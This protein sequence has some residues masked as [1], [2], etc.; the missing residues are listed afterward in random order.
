M[1]GGKRQPQARFD[2][3]L[4]VDD[5]PLDRL[6]RGERRAEGA[7]ELRI[8]DRH[9]LCLDGDADAGGGIRDALA[10]QAVVGDG[11]AL[12][13]L[14]Q[15]V[16][17]GDTH[18][19]ELQLGRIMA[20]AQRVDDAADVKARRVGVDDEAGDAVA[21]LRRVGTGEDQAELRAIGC[22]RGF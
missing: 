2:V 9:L 4:I 13:D 20:R 17:V 5:H 8:L 3:D 7:A 22:G 18:V 1:R 14:A 10:A 12:V 21:A 15:H 19:G 16:A 11:E 6:A